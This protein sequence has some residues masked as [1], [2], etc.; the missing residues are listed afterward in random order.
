MI[1]RFLF[2]ALSLV[3]FCLLV[4][5]G[6]TRRENAEQISCETKQCVEQVAYCIC[7][8]TLTPDDR[9]GCPFTCNT[10]PNNLFTPP[11]YWNLNLT[12]LLLPP[13]DFSGILIGWGKKK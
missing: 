6:P 3:A 1:K 4:N 2:I 7:G 12:G 5:A 13:V 10:C 9:C 11:V 8:S